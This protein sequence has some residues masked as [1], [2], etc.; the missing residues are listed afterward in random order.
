MITPEEIEKLATLARIRLD[1][2][3]KQEMAKE[4]DSI[5]TYM[6]EIKKA[7]IDTDV[8]P[9]PGAVHSVFREDISKDTVPEDREALLTA[10]PDREGEFIAV[11]KII[12]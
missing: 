4:I 8:T 6:D 2:S 10:A 12:G 3:E 5:L 7:T 11:K 9:M 1:E